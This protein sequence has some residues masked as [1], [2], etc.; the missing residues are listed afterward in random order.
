MNMP[1][2]YHAQRGRRK[3]GGS[4]CFGLAVV[5]DSVPAPDLRNTFL[6]PSQFWYKKQ[7]RARRR[8]ARAM[9]DATG[10]ASRLSGS[11]Y[12]GHFPLCLL[13]PRC[14][15]STSS[16]I[17]SAACSGRAT[18]TVRMTGAPF[19]RRCSPL[20]RYRERGAEDVLPRRRGLCRARTLRDPGSRGCPVRRPSAGQPSADGA[21]R[22]ACSPAL[23][24]PKKPQVFFAS[25]SY[26][27]QSWS[28]PRRV[29]AKVEW[30]GGE[31]YPRVGVVVQPEAAGRAGGEV[32]QRARHGGTVGQGGQGRAALDAPVLPRLRANAVPAHSFFAL[33]YNLA[34]F[35]RTLALPEEVAQ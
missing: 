15:S 35:L 3:R 25:C 17:S 20:R 33:A 5:L 4:C 26:H 2:I 6:Q 27:A 19:W 11:P 7:H 14:S 28:K 22:A 16:A 31:L 29:V 32:L 21:D 23:S 18:S 9:A 34:N 30:H 8:V 12:N 10:E 24:A 1:A 13:P